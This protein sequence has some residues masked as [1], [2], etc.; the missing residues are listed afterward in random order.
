MAPRLWQF[1]TD[2]GYNSISQRAAVLSTAISAPSGEA[3]FMTNGELKKLLMSGKPVEHRGITYSHISAIIYR[4]SETVQVELMD[5]FRNSI[6]IASP[7]EVK[8]VNEK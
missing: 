6:V 2:A 8:R 5:K 3:G 1:A 4:K 7:N